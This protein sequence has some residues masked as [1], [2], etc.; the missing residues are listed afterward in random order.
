MRAFILSVLVT[1]A[2]AQITVD[3]KDLEEIFGRPDDPPTSSTTTTTTTTTTV[4]PGPGLETF[5]VKPT[6]TPTTMV[7]K[8]GNACK[9]VPYY[10]CDRDRNGINIKNASVTGW[11][12]LDIR[13]GEDKCQVTVELCCTEPKDEEN[14]VI[15]DVDPSELK[16][17]G[18]RNKKGLDF[19]ISGG[20]G[21]EALFGEFP[22]VI[23]LIDI[24]GSYA[25]VGVL[26]HPQVVMTTAHVAY[27][28]TP[29]NLKIRAGEWDTQT[30]DE[31]L[32]H[33]ER[34]VSEIYIHKDFRK[35]NLFND[36]ALLRLESPVTLGQHINTICLPAQDEDFGQYRD[37]AAN[38]WGKDVF[39]TQGLYAVILKK[40]EIPMVPYSRC[41][42]LL[43]RTRLGN[44]FK[45]HRSFVCAGG[46]E[47]RDLC[48][49]RIKFLLGGTMI[50]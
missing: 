28:Y 9:C 46:E 3:P 24:N 20:S 32:K 27:K 6:D 4:K 15:P 43:R 34:V 18:Y 13:F 40:L 41:Q 47:G 33:Q 19:T 5:T 2:L 42:E 49:V 25:G 7:D 23:A 39:G 38:G 35:N 26:I 1:G 44:N 10:L 14:V 37:C 8:D 30:A 45:L 12:E 11:G 50:W 29:G 22:W 16:G 48:T 21:N 17:C 31:R 36:V